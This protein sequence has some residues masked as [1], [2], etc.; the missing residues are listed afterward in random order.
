MAGHVFLLFSLISFPNHVYFS[1]YFVLFPKFILFFFFSLLFDFI[2]IYSLI[3]TP[4]NLESLFLAGG[5]PLF[6]LGCF[7]FVYTWSF[8]NKHFYFSFSS[9]PHDPSH[10]LPSPWLLLLRKPL[11]RSQ[12]VTLVAARF[13]LF[14]LHPPP[15]SPLPLC[16]KGEV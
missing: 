15:S 8:T 5:M 3:F 4:I 13:L 1:L 11:E 9:L 14:P 12:N 2:W 10:V 7:L 6:P 16:R